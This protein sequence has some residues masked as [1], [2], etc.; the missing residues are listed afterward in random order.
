VYSISHTICSASPIHLNITNNLG[1]SGRKTFFAT[2]DGGPV[3]LKKNIQHLNTRATPFYIETNL[4]PPW[5]AL[6]NT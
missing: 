1:S 4:D 6:D 2:Q 3:K 5:F